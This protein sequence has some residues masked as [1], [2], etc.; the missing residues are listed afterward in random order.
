MNFQNLVPVERGKQYLDLAFK[1][2]REKSSKKITGEWIDKIRTKEMIKLDVVKADLVARLDKVVK[3]FPSFGHLPE[4][5]IE[6][7]KLTLDYKELKRTLGG[8]NWAMDKIKFLQRNYVRKISKGRD[9]GKIKGLRNEFYGRVSS[10]LKQIDKQLVFLEDCRKVMKKYPD[11][12]EAFT[13]VIF[14][15]PNV[16]KTTLLN[17]L[18]GSRA[19][20]AGYSFTTT[21]INSGFLEIKKEALQFL[22]APGTLARPEKMNAIEKIAYLAVRELANVVVYVFDLSG[23]VSLKKQEKLL[24]YLKQNAKKK[25]LLYVSKSDITEAETIADFK[26]KYKKILNLKE[27]K[28]EIERLV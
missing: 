26:K 18:T 10:V 16:G 4:F 15:F 17:K 11:I 24:R 8:L 7:L 20:V 25:I 9:A 13:V 27:L 22:D 21:G 14:G 19:K 2:A 28:Q 6:L 23:A 12:K 3:S 1:K 5:Y